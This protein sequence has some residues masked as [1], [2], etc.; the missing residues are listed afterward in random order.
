MGIITKWNSIILELIN[1]WNVSIRYNSNVLDIQFKINSI[2]I[3]Y[4][5]KNKKKLNY[6]FDFSVH[7]SITVDLSTLSKDS[8]LS[9]IASSFFNKNPSGIKLSNLYELSYGRLVTLSKIFWQLIFCI[10]LMKMI[11]NVIII[12]NLLQYYSK[13]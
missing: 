10:N 5:A 11:A 3:Y 2:V 13:F 4:T 12:Y 1:I 9:R 6:V 7:N 8:K